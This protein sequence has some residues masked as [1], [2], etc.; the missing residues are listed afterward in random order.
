MA[1]PCV[2]RACR[3]ERHDDFLDAEHK[4][5]SCENPNRTDDHH[6]KGRQ[7][8]CLLS[9]PLELLWEIIDELSELVDKTRFMRTCSATRL[10]L[11]QV[12]YEKLFSDAEQ[13]MLGIFLL[14]YASYKGHRDILE[15][16][17]SLRPLDIDQILGPEDTIPCLQSLGSRRLMV[18]AD[19]NRYRN[20]LISPERR[21]APLHYAVM[22][23]D[24]ETVQELLAHR[25]DVNVLDTIG[26]TP[27]SL[28]VDER[29]IRILLDAG[30]SPILSGTSPRGNEAGGALWSFLAGPIFA[31]N[32]NIIP[33]RTTSALRLLIRATKD[34]NPGWNANDK[35]ATSEDTLLKHAIQSGTEFARVMLEA[36]SDPNQST[37]ASNHR[38]YDD[39]LFRTWLGEHP[40]VPPLQ[41]AAALEG[42][43]SV[44]AMRLLIE[45]GARVNQYADNETA[46]TI[47]VRSRD[48]EKVRWLV[49]EAGADVNL[50]ISPAGNDYIVET[51]PPRNFKAVAN[52]ALWQAIRLMDF[53]LV[54][55]LIGLGARVRDVATLPVMGHTMDMWHAGNR[56][57]CNSFDFD[58]SMARLLLAHGAD[59]NV[60]MPMTA[61]YSKNANEARKRKPH[62]WP[63]RVKRHRDKSA[64][65]AWCI[66]GWPNWKGPGLLRACYT[67]S[68]GRRIHSLISEAA[69]DEIIRLNDERSPVHVFQRNTKWTMLC[70]VMLF[71]GTHCLTKIM[72]QVDPLSQ[73]THSSQMRNTPLGMLIRTCNF[74]YTKRSYIGPWTS[75]E[76][77]KVVIF[78]EFFGP[79]VTAK[80]PVGLLAQGLG[81]CVARLTSAK[82][83]ETRI[84][85]Y[86]RMTNCD[87]RWGADGISGLEVLVRHPAYWY[88][89]HRKAHLGGLW[90]RGERHWEINDNLVSAARV[91][92]E[93]SKRKSKSPDAETMQMPWWTTKWWESTGPRRRRS[94][95]QPLPDDEYRAA[96]ETLFEEEMR[97]S[98]K[99]S[100]RSRRGKNKIRFDKKCQ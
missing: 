27:I 62:V 68:A 59:M 84:R 70:E 83:Q 24:T 1:S 50:S 57:R 19:Q 76:W 8:A 10:A 33:R 22:A 90:M 46:L 21:W 54:E 34:A 92:H 25:A 23:Q 6:E 12:I 30:A 16:G 51:Y 20:E 85:D 74:C 98:A 31:R 42:P 63:Q 64:R 79:L 15:V 3:P 9:L 94:R 40:F 26:V 41:I 45:S 11:F 14:C 38:V 13:P 75:W 66:N 35:T 73:L 81:Q 93:M 88:F 18:I 48:R 80:F 55:V 2:I 82:E 28:A 72:G 52:C 32:D 49:Q 58:D 37:W 4:I 43:G 39:K 89:H 17:L 97:S 61:Y 60:S 69:P 78:L 91:V 99:A 77:S 47:A 53:E 65:E 44:E 7:K 5:T 95:Y 100:R 36:G 86:A 71:H 29:M 67:P 87:G 96:F 56:C